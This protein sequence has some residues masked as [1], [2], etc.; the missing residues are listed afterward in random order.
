MR[1]VGEVGEVGARDARGANGVENG[2]RDRGEGMREVG[3]VGARDANGVADGMRHARRR[4]RSVERRS[5]T[6]ELF[7]GVKSV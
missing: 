4:R 2:M 6:R 5:M 1:E 3:E 7:F